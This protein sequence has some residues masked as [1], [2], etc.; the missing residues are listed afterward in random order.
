MLCYDILYLIIS[1]N[2]LRSLV[3]KKKVIKLWL[4]LILRDAL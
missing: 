1:I 3:A 2:L 4:T